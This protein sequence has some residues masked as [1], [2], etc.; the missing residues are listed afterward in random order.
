MQQF[1]TLDL[2]KTGLSK[3]SI[4]ALKKKRIIQDRLNAHWF[5]DECEE[6]HDYIFNGNETLEVCNRNL[7]SLGVKVSDSA[8]TYQV[9]STWHC[10]EELKN[11]N[12][13][14]H[15]PNSNFEQFVPIGTNKDLQVW[16]LHT[17]PYNLN[18]KDFNQIAKAFP[19][20]KLILITMEPF[21]LPPDLQ[22]SLNSFNYATISIDEL[23]TKDLR[24]YR[25]IAKIL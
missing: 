23:L 16:W 15:I 11:V 25:E 14:T 19:F 20:K 4:N 8:R 2:A 21:L 9:L 17:Y 22:E 10:N 3:R 12:S 18:K 1:F 24:G 5:C 13:L 6:E 7:H